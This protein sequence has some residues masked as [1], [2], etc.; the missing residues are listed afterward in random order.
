MKLLEN[1]AQFVT[2][3][4]GTASAFC[5]ATLGILLW[6]VTGPVFAY[7]DTWQL[8]VN[9]STTIVTFL[10]VFL[11]QRSQNKEMLSIQVKLD[12][13]IRA[14]PQANNLIIPLEG[15]PEEIVRSVHAKYAQVAYSSNR[16]VPEVHIEDIL[17]VENMA[18]K[19]KHNDVPPS[20]IP[21]EL[22]TTEGKESLERTKAEVSEADPKD[23][24]ERFAK[25]IEGNPTTNGSGA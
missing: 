22:H 25:L 16:G 4:S 14:I 7:S 17:K 10:M 3:W 12:E 6:L 11:I 15:L 9:T 1:F 5:V 8:V 21:G 18:N 24:P 23:A 2:K 19:N 13:L 20:L